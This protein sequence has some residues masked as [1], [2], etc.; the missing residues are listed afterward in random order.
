[1]A[2]RIRR[3]CTECGDLFTVDVDDPLAICNACYSRA[4]PV[5]TTVPGCRLVTALHVTAM[6]VGV[7]SALCAVATLWTL[8]IGEW[9]ASAIVAAGMIHH[10]ATSLGLAG[11]AHLIRARP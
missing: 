8:W 9:S 7:C 3:K 11:L 10:L 5:A 6:I 1:M 2:S 4:L